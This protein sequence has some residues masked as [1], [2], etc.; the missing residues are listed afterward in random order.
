MEKTHQKLRKRFLSLL[1]IC[2][3]MFSTFPMTAYAKTDTSDS[4]QMLPVSIRNADGQ[5][6]LSRVYTLE[7]IEKSCED[8]TV[9]FS[10][11]DSLDVP[12]LTAVKGVS[13]S[14][15]M[16]K[17]ATDLGFNLS[18][19]DKVTMNISDGDAAATIYDGSQ[20]EDIGYYFPGLFAYDKITSETS[21]QKIKDGGKT[22]VVPMLALRSYQGRIT[23]LKTLSGEAELDQIKSWMEK[24]MDQFATFR[25][26]TG[27]TMEDLENKTQ[28]TNRY[29]KWLYKMTI[30]LKNPPE[31]NAAKLSDP[32]FAVT[33]SEDGSTIYARI[34]N[35]NAGSNLYYSINSGDNADDF[36]GYIPQTLYTE[37][38]KFQRA[39]LGNYNNSQI[40]LRA[41][42]SKIY[43]VDSD[44]QQYTISNQSYE[45]E[46]EPVVK[47]GSYTE[48]A[49]AVAAAS[50]D[51]Q[52]V[53]SLTQGFEWTGT[54][55]ITGK[56]IK[57]LNGTGG[58]ITIANVRTFTNSAT[59]A[60]VLGNGTISFGENIH[61]AGKTGSSRGYY[62]L[63]VHQG[64]NVT[65]N[66]DVSGSAN[67]AGTKI[68]GGLLAVGSVVTVNGNIS[69]ADQNMVIATGGDGGTG[70]IADGST[71]SVN[72][73]LRGGS[74]IGL[75]EASSSTYIL[76]GAGAEIKNGSTAFVEGDVQGGN[77]ST[78]QSLSAGG[79]GV[80][81]T[82]SRLSVTGDIAGGKGYLSARASSVE[83]PPYN[84]GCV[85]FGGNSV[86]EVKKDSLD[87][88]KGGNITG[89]DCISGQGGSGIRVDSVSGAVIKVEGSVTGGSSVDS[90]GGIG[91]TAAG[92]EEN[93][94]ESAIQISG[95]V[96]CGLDSL[97]SAAGDRNYGILITGGVTGTI[98]VGGS[99]SGKAAG[100]VNAQNC[101]IEV[102]GDV[103][104]NTGTGI[105]TSAG[106]I[107]TAGNVMGGVNGVEAIASTRDTSVQVDGDI[108]GTSNYGAI[109]AQLEN[110]QATI[111]YKG[112]AAGGVSA[113]ADNAAVKTLLGEGYTVGTYEELKP[114][115]AVSPYTTEITGG[116]A[117]LTVTAEGKVDN[118]I[119]AGTPVSLSITD[120]LSGYSVE[121]VSVSAATATV[122]L[123]KVSDGEYT[124]TMP[125][126]AIKI[127]VKLKSSGT[128]IDDNGGG[129]GGGGG[130]GGGGSSS[131]ASLSKDSSGQQKAVASRSVTAKM[132][133]SGKATATI[134]KSE[135]NGAFLSAQDAAKAADK[136]A[137]AQSGTTGIEVKVEVKGA[138][139]A[140]SVEA[141]LPSDA[142]K[143]IATQE[144]AVLTVSSAVAEIT[145]DQDAL[146]AVTN[147]ADN[148]ITLHAAKVDSSALPAAAK[149]EIGDAPVYDFKVIGSNGPISDFKHGTATVRIP[150]ELKLGQSGS[151][152]A[153]YYIDDEG[154]L[155]KVDC[156]YD[157]A[158]KTATFT[159]G[160]FSYYAIV[161]ETA[162]AEFSDVKKTAY[163]YDAVMYAVKAGLVNGT[164]TSTFGPDT[165]M[166]RA[167]F[168]TILGRASGINAADYGA[169][170]FSDVAPGNW[171]SAY[172][173]WGYENK[174]VSGMGGGTFGPEHQI[175]RAQMAS[176][177][178]RYSAWKGIDTGNV[179]GS[180]T[181]SEAAI[182]TSG[183]ISGEPEG[184]SSEVLDYTDLATIPD[185]A[186]DGVEFCSEKG[187]FTGYPDGSFQPKKTATRAEAVTVL[188]KGSR[189]LF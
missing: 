128:P 150:Y 188:F 182:E 11:I 125:E 26:C 69:G 2:I 132:D 107:N 60:T 45:V 10:S 7:E 25:F 137:G 101:R 72:G 49:G 104:A 114:P 175:T 16:A 87:S 51:S 122:E 166:T 57:I 92:T 61:F 183:T 138:S 21:I 48:L 17:I 102:A 47:V 126:E 53:L 167:M 35:P 96:S 106:A 135:L 103:T 79:P 73:N 116:T 4:A 108:T 93:L 89:G 13:V 59:Y 185:W 180:K 75:G 91:L 115:R 27:Q 184:H 32:T 14:D 39:D 165:G 74:T 80:S 36:T 169:S 158:T 177:L 46:A 127:L 156:T 164:G 186:S 76:G 58:E 22:E 33:Q 148:Q 38:L 40:K 3:L 136:K 181:D 118:K 117:T 173:Q 113:T 28:M 63:S 112:T 5:N 30:T 9:F 77:A 24:K 154:K 168:L 162:A 133:A 29:Y 64:A 174:L 179:S 145:L 31:N 84:A 110:Y 81:L 139:N 82:G 18:D 42:V 159:T 19:I 160:H 189:D 98:T 62:G 111:T 86:L 54:L 34:N 149:S 88:T 99:V 95:D 172:V 23:Y 187:W 56:K 8:A 119:P 67:S 109:A 6:V 153:V 129:T 37:K 55:N 134:A 65:V 100:I 141:V 50:S 94:K 41:K 144:N 130:G 123:T 142:L 120:I 121:S 78:T 152:V 71:V 43:S 68:G 147:K 146:T 140:K 176:I 170:S 143:E 20:R 124:F 178:E 131:D 155:T 70:L 44:V 52:I 105:L 97:L 83:L 171:Y 85:V 15:L 1:L 151:Q 66:G 12:I 90:Y 161:T 163:Y 157:A